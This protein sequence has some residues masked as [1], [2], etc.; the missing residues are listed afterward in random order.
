MF[1]GKISPAL[2]YLPRACGQNH[3]SFGR[4]MKLGIAPGFSFMTIEPRKQ[5]GLTFHFTCWLIGILIV[6]YSH[7]HRTVVV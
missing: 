7:P 2:G 4:S 5:V 1:F 3:C 6:V